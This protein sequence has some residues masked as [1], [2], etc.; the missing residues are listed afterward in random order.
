MSTHFSRK[1]R[2]RIDLATV[3]EEPQVDLDPYDISPSCSSQHSMDMHCANFALNLM[4]KLK[5]PTSG[6]DTIK[7]KQ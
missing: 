4:A 1:H 3:P 7:K 5:I 2:Q 6:V